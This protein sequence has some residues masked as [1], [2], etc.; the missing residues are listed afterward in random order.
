MR[1]LL[2]L[3]L[4][5]HLRQRLRLKPRALTP[6]VLDTQRKRSI[7]ELMELPLVAADAEVILCGNVSQG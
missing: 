5:E 7:G 2:V 4:V 6:L 1:L 3:K